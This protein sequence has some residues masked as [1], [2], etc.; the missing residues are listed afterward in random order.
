MSNAATPGSPPISPAPER[1]AS[2]RHGHLIKPGKFLGD[3][4][5]KKKTFELVASDGAALVLKHGQGESA[6]GSPTRAVKEFHLGRESGALPHPGTNFFTVY[7]LVATPNHGRKLKLEAESEA[8]RDEW[9]KAINDGVRSLL[10]PASPP[11]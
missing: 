4:T 11:S 2:L 8:S 7:Q 3:V 5:K 9:V 1:S 10:P 6:D